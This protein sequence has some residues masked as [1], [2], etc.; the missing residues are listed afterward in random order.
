MAALAVPLIFLYFG[1]GLIS[2]AIDKRRDRKS[3]RISDDAATS[4][5][6]V[7]PIDSPKEI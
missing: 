5:D 1:A 3:S 6:Q 4:I 2:L 7:T